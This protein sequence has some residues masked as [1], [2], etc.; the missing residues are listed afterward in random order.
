MRIEGSYTFTAPL[1]QLSAALRNPDTL[2]RALPG[3]ERLTQ[4]G[5]TGADGISSYEVRLRLRSNTPPI[6]ANVRVETPSEREVR[7][8]ADG[9]GWDG[10]F[11]AR[12]AMTLLTHGEG[13]QATYIWE[14]QPDGPSAEGSS[15][16]QSLAET[17]CGWLDNQA[18]EPTLAR[19]GTGPLL[20]ETPRGRIARQVELTGAAPARRTTNRALLIGAGATLGLGVLVLSMRVL[21]RLSGGRGGDE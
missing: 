3:C 20:V 17:F 19:R 12:G 2:A 10:A 4:M 5:P 14:T 11:H 7:A 21:R 18:H 13:T 8:E 1:S 6:Q 15:M 9:L 16:G